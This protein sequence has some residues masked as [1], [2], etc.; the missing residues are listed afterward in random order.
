MNKELIKKYKAEFDHWLNGG[1]VISKYT[2]IPTWSD[3]QSEDIWRITDENISKVL[4]VINDEYAT[5]RKALAEGKIVEV[6]TDHNDIDGYIWESMED[7]EFHHFN[8]DEIRIKPEE[9]KFKVGDWVV[10]RIN[11]IGQILQEDY[12]GKGLYKI[13]NTHALK[14]E[15]GTSAKDLTIWKPKTGEWCWVYDDIT[16]V[17]VLRKFVCFDNDFNAPLKHIVEN[18]DGRSTLPFKHIEPFIGVLPL[19][20]ENTKKD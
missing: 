13:S 9:P 15:V 6:A 8:I 16:K 19:K 20:I 4:I 11:E 10:N 7:D 18:H 3:C 1:K 12:K 2:L 5:Y 17:P 14:C